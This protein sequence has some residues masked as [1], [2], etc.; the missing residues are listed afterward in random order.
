MAYKVEKD[1]PELSVNGEAAIQSLS[2]ASWGQAPVAGV[3]LS[4]QFSTEYASENHNGVLTIHPTVLYVFA[5]GND[6]KNISVEAIQP[7]DWGGHQND[8]AI[9]VGAANPDGSYW[10][11]SNWGTSA[12][13][14]AAPGCAVPSLGWNSVTSNFKDV[15]LSGTSVAA[16]LVS[17]AGNLLRDLI[18]P[19]RIKSRIL[20]SG[21]YFSSLSDK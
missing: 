6:T 15:R 2:G 13:D 19:A 21:R 3:N 12:V 7:A 18:E 4:L 11:R 8:N 9:T 14:L 1:A 5:A 10:I 16:P 20:S 17:F